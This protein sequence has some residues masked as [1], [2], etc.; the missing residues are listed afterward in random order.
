MQLL[1]GLNTAGDWAC[2]AAIHR[3][4]ACPLW[5]ARHGKAASASRHEGEVHWL[6]WRLGWDPATAREKVRAAR[7]LGALPAIDEALPSARLS[8]AKVRALTRVATPDNEGTLLEM[9]LVA[10]GAQL[11]RL[12]RGYRGVLDGERPPAPE[13]RSVRLR[14]LPGGMVKLELVLEPDLCRLSDYADFG[15]PRIVGTRGRTAVS[16]RAGGIIKARS[17]KPAGGREA[18]NDG[19]PRGLELSSLGHVPLRR[20]RLRDKREWFRP[21][22]VR[23]TVR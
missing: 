5:N 1:P 22:R 23:A 12:C 15:G 17:G 10:T 14:L 13:E 7:G 20:G 9:A 16:T 8:Y 6:A 2:T 4:A 11:E 18:G 3:E 21:T 19:R